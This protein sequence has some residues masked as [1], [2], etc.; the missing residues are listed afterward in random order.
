MYVTTTATV[1][2]RPVAAATAQAA[3]RSNVPSDLGGA[4]P[5]LSGGD[6]AQ[7]LRRVPAVGVDVE[8]VVPQVDA[9]GGEAEG[10]EGEQRGAQLGPVVEHTGGT[11]RGEHE[12]VLRPLQRSRRAHDRPPTVE[13]CAGARRPSPDVASTT[14]V[15]DHGDASL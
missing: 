1:C 11:R 2:H 13:S 10:D 6:R 9:A 5:E 14:P 8:D 4:D 3:T 7:P 15:D 12:E